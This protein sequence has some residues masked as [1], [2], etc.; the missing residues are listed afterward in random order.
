MAS[1][2]K[3]TGIYIFKFNRKWLLNPKYS[4]WL[5]PDESCDK[6]A[7][8]K[9]CVCKIALNPIGP[10]SLVIHMNSKRHQSQIKEPKKNSWVSFRTHLSHRIK[11]FH[12][13][14]CLVMFD[15]LENAAHKMDE[16]SENFIAY[17][18]SSIEED[19]LEDEMRKEKWIKFKE[20]FHF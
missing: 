10:V 12:V 20:Q 15:S 14:I 8:C 7:V 17:L 16:S 2:S 18:Q 6:S 19:K 4:Q 5:M 3:E 11:V 1:F 13:L 9:V